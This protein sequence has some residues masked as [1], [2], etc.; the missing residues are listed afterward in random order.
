MENGQKVKL[1]LQFKGRQI[2]KQEFGYDVINQVIESVSDCSQ[3]E[4]EP[5]MIGKKL[6]AQLMPKK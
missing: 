1:S 6:I 2:T 5:K 3:V 4:I